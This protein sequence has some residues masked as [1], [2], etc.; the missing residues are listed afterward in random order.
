LV[1]SRFGALRI[2]KE[3]MLDLQAEGLVAPEEIQTHL[4]R[5]LDNLGSPPVA[6]VLPQDVSISQIVD[7]PPTSEGDIRK[8][9]EEETVKLAGVSESRI[10]YDFVRLEIPG[11]QRQQFWVTFCQEGEIRERVRTLGVEAEDVCEVTTTANALMNSYRASAPRPERVILVHL[12]AQSTVVVV[13]VAGQPAFASSY[14]MGGDFFTRSLARIRNS[15]E[16]AAENLKR[17]EDLLTGPKADK[18]FTAAVD[19]WAAE[20]KRQLKDWFEQ[21]PGAPA[22]LSNY[23]WTVSGD[24]FEQPG[25]LEYLR[26]KAGL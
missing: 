5:T 25:L 26:T 3:E 13:L 11:Q 17:S 23:E 10:V 18:Q 19:G 7:L 4:L 6:I 16:A 22:D 2:L 9:I 21:H 1:E 15:S 14:Q 20:L 24:G 8:L 12:G